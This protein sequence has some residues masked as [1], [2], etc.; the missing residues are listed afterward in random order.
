MKSILGR[1]DKN[2]RIAVLLGGIAVGMVG[3]AYGFVPAYQL[4][5]QVTGLAGTPKTDGI[6]SAAVVDRD[7]T[8]RLDANT[9]AGLPWRF[10]PAVSEVT[11]KLGEE[12]LTYYQAANLSDRAVAGHAT[13]NVTPLKA[14]QYF[15][16]IDC[17]CFQDQTLEAGQEVPMPVLFYVDPALAEDPLV[18]EVTTITLSYTFF[19]QRADVAAAEPEDH[20]RAAPADFGQMTR[21]ERRGDAS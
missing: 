19:P 15:V 11:L 1:L 14:A 20:A 16:K 6:A 10:A 7:I 5:C 18:N 3:F 8:V 12:H 2:T 17:F 13:F 21:T 9:H 4:F